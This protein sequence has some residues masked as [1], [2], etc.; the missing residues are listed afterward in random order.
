M[1]LRK[2]V[3]PKRRCNAGRLPAFLS[4]YRHARRVIVETAIAN[5]Q[6]DAGDAAETLRR[7]LTCGNPNAEIPLPQRSWS[8]R[9]KA[10]NW[11]ISWTK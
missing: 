11:P 9:S 3:S 7:N 10:S 4:D 6:R 8:K 1:P 2:R 5:L